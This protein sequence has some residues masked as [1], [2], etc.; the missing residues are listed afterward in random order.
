M[1]IS[2]LTLIIVF[3]IG[4]ESHEKIS[5]SGKFI[6]TSGSNYFYSLD[7]KTKK[8][9]LILNTDGM[10]PRLTKINNVEFLFSVEPIYGTSK[11][12]KFSLV[13]NLCEE[14]ISGYAPTYIKKYNKLFYYRKEKENHNLYCA[15]FDSLL[16]GKSI[17]LRMLSNP[18]SNTLRNNPVLQ[19]SD[20]EVIF[21]DEN[22]FLIK[23]NFLTNSKQKTYFNKLYPLAFREKSQE[24]FCW[25]WDYSGYLV[26][27]LTTGEKNELPI[28]YSRLKLIYNKEK[29]ALIYSKSR[30]W[31]LNE[32]SDLYYYS[33]SDK[34]EY[35]LVDGAH[36]FD[37]IFFSK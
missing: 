34:K 9:K 3:L 14:L 11:I 25:K 29:D 20:K 26:I 22:G 12:F 28:D 27:N 23:Y 4:C 24:L 16:N 32:T 6:I 35:L 37:A 8:N 15:N 1:K 5:F 21:V 17:G 2:V 13:S 30:K 7:S 31:S 36:I 18:A 19:I 10:V 33:F